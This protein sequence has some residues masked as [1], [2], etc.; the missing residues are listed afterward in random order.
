VTVIALLLAPGLLMLA[1]QPALAIQDSCILIP[2][3]NMEEDNPP[4]YYYLAG[5]GA[6]FSRSSA[7]YYS[8]SYSGALTR[9]GYDT[10]ASTSMSGLVE[11][12]GMVIATYLVNGYSVGDAWFLGCELVEPVNTNLRIIYEEAGHYN[13]H[14]NKTISG[15]PGMLNQM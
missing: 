7:C 6:S 11:T 14:T 1:P 8:G 10:V 15:V 13:H 5:Q 9:N 4:T 3:E 2:N 12:A